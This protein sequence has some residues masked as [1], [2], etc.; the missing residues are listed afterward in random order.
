[1][2][3]SQTVETV[4]TP[5]PVASIAD[6]AAMHPIDA[7][8]EVRQ[9][10]PVD[11]DPT[12]GMT[13]AQKAEHHS[14]QQRRKDDGKFDE[15]KKRNR[16]KSQQASP[17]DVPRIQKLTVE[18]NNERDRAERA[19]HE[20]ATLRASHAAP[21]K[22]EAAERKVEAAGGDPSDPEPVED[23]AKFGGDYGKFLQAQARWAARDERRQEIA[24]ETKQRT[25]AQHRDAETNT[26]KAFDQ[27]IQKA[28]EKYEDFDEVLAAPVKWT[29][30]SPTDMFILED[31]NGPDV[32]YHLRHHPD[33]AD[34]LVKMSPVMQV[35]TLALLSQ[36]YASESSAV[37]GTTGAASPRKPGYTPPKPPTPVRTE[38]QRGSDLAQK[39]EAHSIAEH[40]A[41]YPVKR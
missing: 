22:I 9:P 39:G 8:V 6:H 41:Q 2:S 19:E 18:R 30:G 24:R 12:A 11:V 31:D 26:W 3:E 13:D 21:A 10:D 7:P 1:M 23:D 33:E 37:A 36:R 34:A 32:L 4:E 25:D 16:A 38:G 20:L 14:A 5:E 27:R 40:A 15:G 35:R 29:V 17:E 28:Q